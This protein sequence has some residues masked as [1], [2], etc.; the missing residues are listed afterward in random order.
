[1]PERLFNLLIAF[2]IFIITF[3]VFLFISLV[4]KLNSKGP[5]FFIQK[6]VGQYNIDFNLYKFRTMVVQKENNQLI[7][8]GNDKRITNVGKIL[9]KFKLDELPQLI[10]IIKGDMNIVGPRPE[11]R[12]YVELYSAEQLKIL[13][14]KPGLTDPSS[15][16]FSNESEIL[17][18]Y[19]NPE[20]AYIKIIMPEKINTSI[21]YLEKRNMLTDIQIIINTIIKVFS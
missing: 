17:G 7:T 8:I 16:K 19:K 9:R 1:M 6:R 5:V 2:F 11:V 18:K 10:N 15:I 21:N 20:E 14:A 4:I 12:K 13:N 3:P